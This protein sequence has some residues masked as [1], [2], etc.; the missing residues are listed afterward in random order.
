MHVRQAGEDELSCGIDHIGAGGMISQRGLDGRDPIA[1]HHDR[2]VSFRDA[3]VHVDDCD[4]IEHCGPFR[5]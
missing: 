5:A 4:V 2:H 3:S 1:G